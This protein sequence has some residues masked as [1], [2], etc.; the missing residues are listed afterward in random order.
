MKKKKKTNA[1]NDAARRRKE[2]LSLMAVQEK[3]GLFKPKKKLQKDSE[4]HDFLEKKPL[5]LI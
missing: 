5:G 2:T 1:Q 3:L 4:A